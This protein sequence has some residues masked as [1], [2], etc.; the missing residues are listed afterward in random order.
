MLLVHHIIEVLYLRYSFLSVS[1]QLTTYPFSPQ[2][3]A[4]CG[5]ADPLLAQQLRR[6]ALAWER[7]VI[8]GGRVG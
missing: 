7:E 6:E 5:R 3:G 1:R 2:G 8:M 4:C